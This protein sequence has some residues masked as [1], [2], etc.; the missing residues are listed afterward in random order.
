[1]QEKLSHYWGLKEGDKLKDKKIV[2]INFYEDK[3]DGNHLKIIKLDDG[4]EFL[5]DNFGLRKLELIE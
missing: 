3:Y 5:L 2:K 1:M 4:S